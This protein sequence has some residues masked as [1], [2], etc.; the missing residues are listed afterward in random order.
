MADLPVGDNLQDQVMTDGITFY[1]NFSGVSITVARAESF[2]GALGYSIFG[3]GK[4][5]FVLFVCIQWLSNLTELFL[6]LE[7]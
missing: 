1:T 5:F 2:A 6:Q 3:T 7:M 4:I